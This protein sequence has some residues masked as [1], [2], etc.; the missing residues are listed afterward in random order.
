MKPH[1]TVPSQVNLSQPFVSTAPTSG[2]INSQA[3]V[4][5]RLLQE[6]AS[7]RSK[8]TQKYVSTQPQVV[9]KTSTTSVNGSKPSQEFKKPVDVCPKA[10]IS[11]V[12]VPSQG[13]KKTLV[14]ETANKFKVSDRAKPKSTSMET[15]PQR[16][17]KGSVNNANQSKAVE[18]GANGTHFRSS[19]SSSNQTDRSKNQGQPKATD[20]SA[21]YN[22]SLDENVEA[23]RLVTQVQKTSPVHVQEQQ[24]RRN[25]SRAPGDSTLDL[26]GMEEVRHQLQSMMRLS[27]A[28]MSPQE[29]SQYEQSDILAGFGV[30]FG[31]QAT[32]M[33]M[34]WA[35]MRKPDE[36]IQET[37]PSFSSQYF[38]DS[39]NHSRSDASVHAENQRLRDMLEKERYRRRHCEQYI[40]QLNVKLLETQQQVAVAV[41]TD[42]RKDIMIEQLDKQLARVMEGWKKR[43]QEKE[44]MMEELRKEKEEIE[45]KM[46]QQKQMIN[47]FEHDMSEAV[48]ALRKEKEKAANEIEELKA[49]LQDEGRRYQ[50]TGDLL[51]GEREKVGLLQQECESL[52]EGR[53][54]LDK[55]L[56]NM[57]RR[58]HREQD[59]WF[60]RE[61]E[62]L[63]RI[64]EVSDKNTKIL[65]SERAK[66]EEQVKLAEEIMDQY[67][68]TTNRLKKMELEL[69]AALREKES[70]KVEMSI[71]EAKFENA[72]RV[73]EADLHSTMEKQIAEQ[74]ADVQVRH[75]VV[76]DETREKHRQQILDLSRR[77]GTEMER[78][79]AVFKEEVARK[80]DEFRKQF[81]EMETRLMEYRNENSEL[82]RSKQRLESTRLEILTKL[83]YAM[84]SQW[85]EALSLLSATPQRRTTQSRTDDAD[86]T[87]SS[88]LTTSTSIPAV[89]FS[90]LTPR[91]QPANQASESHHSTN[92]KEPHT[93]PR[94]QHTNQSHAHSLTNQMSPTMSSAIHL[95]PVLG[96]STNQDHGSILSPGRESYVSHS[97]EKDRDDAN[98]ETAALSH[99]K[100]FQDYLNSF[101]KTPELISSINSQAEMHGGGSVTSTPRLPSPPEIAALLSTH[102]H[103]I[104][105]M[106]HHPAV[107]SQSGQAFHPVKS[108]VA[109]QM[110]G[111]RLFNQ[112]S[113]SLHSASQ[114][115]SL[116]TNQRELDLSQQ[117]SSLPASLNFQP[118][119]STR[120]PV[121]QTET[122]PPRMKPSNQIELS[123]SNLNQTDITV[124]SDLANQT[125]ASMPGMLWDGSNRA[126]PIRPPQQCDDAYANEDNQSIISGVSVGVARGYFQ[127]GQSFSPPTRQHRDSENNSVDDLT[128]Q[129]YRLNEDYSDL[130]ERVQRHESHQNELQHYIQLLLNRSP[131]E[132]NTSQHTDSVLSQDNEDL[133]LNDTAQAAQLQR[134]LDRIQE[135]RTKQEVK[136]GS[137]VKDAQTSKILSPDQIEEVT[138]LLNQ[139]KG[140]GQLP[141][142]SLPSNPQVAELIK[143]LS[144]AQLGNQ[145]VAR[146]P[147]RQHGNHGNHHRAIGV[148][149]NVH[150]NPSKGAEGGKQESKKPDKS[151]QLTPSGDPKVAQLAPAKKVERKLAG[152]VVKG[153]KPQPGSATKGDKS[154][155]PAA[156][157]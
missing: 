137:A 136:Q 147:G 144:Q 98:I 131:N 97:T 106:A 11:S 39:G 102:L 95:S 28:H 128:H 66:N 120:F 33:D 153:E 4:S 17:Q 69:D 101:T 151:Q 141:D 68:E 111:A 8:T 113:H 118:I 73:L 2:G 145:S 112:P 103:N 22:D 155:K 99:L 91:P 121:N 156:W 29:R 92:Q 48:D 51:E 124:Y 127:G 110:Q 15:L 41:S 96:K 104:Q 116:L 70:V 16:Q 63:Q 122:P 126:V 84:Q 38:T 72:Q 86:D 32:N 3:G 90:L 119:S 43:D 143:L 71:M 76:L 132:A 18:H 42:K 133:D 83:Q 59:E 36:E 45:D 134:E 81:Q 150:F 35:P 7:H 80:E 54:T 55:K 88:I 31:D 47:N 26:A 87:N 67:Q 1:D 5:S 94:Q 85:N 74:I 56:D 82:K 46:M 77:N 93:P 129:S 75:E 24:E 9:P 148:R 44:E 157:K 117:H 52:R 19:T 49:K 50:H 115:N 40:Q 138:K 130:S 23:S 34:S 57:Q 79:L 25:Q 53:E 30:D 140:Q 123:H 62:L 154:Q 61:Q 13:A 135:L 64:E 107:Q 114:P 6:T 20:N 100:Q 149:R 21:G 139:V 12:H 58:L 125:A 65:Q 108:S 146:K 60:Q 142:T 105:H 27:Q 78:Q 14:N 89:N 10:V 37:F 152:A 109:N